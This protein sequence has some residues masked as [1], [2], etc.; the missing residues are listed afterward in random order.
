M[1]HYYYQKYPYLNY[2]YRDTDGFIWTMF[3][4]P[5]EMLVAEFANTFGRPPKT[6]FD[7][8]AA[9][10]VIVWRAERM[11]MDARGI[12]IKKYPYQCSCY[13]ELFKNGKIQIKSIL[14]SEP[15]IADLVFC[16]GTLTYFT[17]DELAQVLDKF[18]PCKMLCAIHNTTEDVD[19]AK[20]NGD[21]LTTCNKP[22][23]I[24]PRQ[25]WMDT[26]AQNGFSPRYAAHL[27][28]FC[29]TPVRSA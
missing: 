28:C 1:P 17:E 16:N 7:C 3:S 14:D 8:G 24:R 10:G 12:D 15:I 5:P 18:R 13:D 2:N 22:R 4:I 29:A 9:T 19:A 6:F 20:A 25:W 27:Q 11:G 26:F 23:L 21:E